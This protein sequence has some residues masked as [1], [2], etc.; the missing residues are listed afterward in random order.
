MSYRVNID[1]SEQT[2]YGAFETKG[3][4]YYYSPD[5]VRAIE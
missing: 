4:E 5:S 2:E 3:Q 1:Y